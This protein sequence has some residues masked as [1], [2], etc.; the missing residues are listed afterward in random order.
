MRG[1]PLRPLRFA[2]FW[3][4]IA[5]LTL[6][7]SFLLP[8]I[9]LP[10]HW[11]RAIVTSYLFL[12]LGLLRVI[13]GVSWEIRGDV[14]G[15]KGP[16][17]VA[18]KHQSAFE[19]LFLQ[20]VLGDPAIIAKREL[21]SVPLIGWVQRRLGHIGADRSGNLDAARQLLQAARRAHDDGRP[22]VIF[23]EGSRRSPGAAPDYKP[24]VDVLYGVLKTA[25]IPVAVN[26]GRVWPAR[27]LFPYPGH[28]VLAF[29]PAIPSRLPRAAFRQKLI[30]DI[31][32]A[33]QRLLDEPAGR[34]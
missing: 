9:L 14:A 8:A 29:L 13:A 26:S 24:G 10:R 28:I 17:L 21:L 32:T 19:T 16:V 25:C 23:P 33:S 6:S 22:V 20:Y 27:A 12:V 31:E 4:L 30:E 2:V 15:A 18:A 5:V 1:G 3:F 34:A 11:V 7:Y